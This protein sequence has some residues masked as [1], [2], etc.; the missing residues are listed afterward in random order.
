MSKCWR[1]QM[2]EASHPFTPDR[3]SWTLTNHRTIKESF[4]HRLH[5]R[6][7]REAGFRE[8]GLPPHWVMDKAS[9]LQ[10]E[11]SPTSSSLSLDFKQILC[12]QI[13]SPNS[14]FPFTALQER[15][16]KPVHFLDE[17]WRAEGHSSVFLFIRAIHERGIL[18][19]DTKQRPHPLKPQRNCHVSCLSLSYCCFPPD[20]N[21]FWQ[22]KILS[23]QNWTK[24]QW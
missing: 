8:A 2:E 16:S 19:Q 4:T 23:K 12:S 24:R 3:I 18:E 13:W 21:S 11:K 14:C 1:S 6:G 22:E 7:L 9:N 5:R 15:S 20:S 10:T 17:V